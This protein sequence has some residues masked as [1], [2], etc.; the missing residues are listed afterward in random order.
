[1]RTKERRWYAGCLQLVLL[2]AGGGVFAVLCMTVVYLLP[3]GRM[4]QN[5]KS[6]MAVFYTEGVYPQQVSGYKST[7][8][9]NET[10]AIMLLNAIYDGGGRTAL[11]RAMRVER[12][13]FSDT[14]ASCNAL[15]QYA[16][17]N[18]QPDSVAEYSRYWHGYLLWLK[19]LL[20]LLDYADIRMLHMMTQVLL[21]FLLIGTMA[22]RETL[23]RYLLPLALAVIVANPA[24]TAMSLQFSCIYEISLSAMILILLRHE[25][26]EENGGYPRV[27]FLLGMITVFFDFLTYPTAALG[28]PLLLVLL[29][30]RCPVGRGIRHTVGYSACF[31]LGYAGMWGGKWLAASLL[32]RE[33]VFH[34]A[35]S[36]IFLHTGSAVVDGEALSHFDVIF[37][38]LRVLMRWPY[39]LLFGLAFCWCVLRLWKKKIR[40]KALVGGLPLL[41]AALIPVLWIFLTSSHAAWCYWYTYRGLMVTAFGVFCFLQADGLTGEACDAV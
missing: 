12:I 26:W 20:L 17:E 14:P 1:M 10:D 18:R 40:P 39:L 4:E 2:L 6:S 11:E 27:F 9:D 19:P 36:Q 35:V 25:K 7:Q 21:L 13:A 23:R 8:L 30:Q 34:T 37:R 5:V 28:M 38:N 29:L 24:A 32:L 41:A 31:G 3:V 22:K 33:N 16:W 15:I